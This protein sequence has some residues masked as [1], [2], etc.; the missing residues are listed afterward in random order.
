[1]KRCVLFAN[2][3][4]I[5]LAVV[6]FGA[7]A[8]SKS[9]QGFCGSG[10][11]G[12]MTATCSATNVATF[13]YTA[14]GANNG[15]TFFVGC[16]STNAVT[17][18]TLTASGWTM[19]QVGGI[20]GSTTNGQGVMWRAY[21]PNTTQATFTATFTTTGSSCNTFMSDNIDEWTGMDT[22]NFADAS[23]ATPGT[24]ASG[25]PTTS[26][27]PTVNNAMV[28]AYA[29]DTVTAV[30]TIGGTTA[31][32]GADDTQGDWSEYRLMSGQSGVSQTCIF[33]GS[34]ASVA[35][36]MTIKPPSATAAPKL[37]LLGVGQ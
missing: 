33:T 6:C 35:A 14:N 9:D 26:V 10:K 23:S 30:N 11:G 22:S 5:A 18:A 2:V 16:S 4:A 37:T 28:V 32:K 7:V 34:G 12:N 31:T 1:M 25:N 17:S 29:L 15:V 3:L 19:T 13:T 8:H 36:A 24:A 27:T 20:Y 21:A